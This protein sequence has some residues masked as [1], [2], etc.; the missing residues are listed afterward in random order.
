MTRSRMLLTLTAL[1]PWSPGRG[2]GRRS[3]RRGGPP[4]RGEAPLGAGQGAPGR[5]GH[6]LEARGEALDRGA[7]RP[8][9]G[10]AGRRGGEGGHPRLVPHPRAPTS[11]SGST[12]S[13]SWTGCTCSRA[14]TR[15][16]TTPPSPRTCRSTARPRPTRKN[17]DYLTVRES[18]AGPGGRHADPLR[19]PRRQDRGRLQQRAADRQLR[20]LRHPR[21][22][23]HA[24]GHQQLRLPRA[25]RLRPVRRAAGRPDLVHL[26]GRG[27][28]PGDGRLQ[29]PARR[30]LH[31]PAADPLR[32]RHPQPGHLHRLAGELRHLR[33]RRRRHRQRLADARLRGPLGPRLRLRGAVAARH[34]PGDAPQE[35]RHR[36]GR[37]LLRHRRHQAGL[38]RGRQRP[39]QGPR[40]RGLRHLGRHLR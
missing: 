8:G 28:L 6:V 31:P 40:R 27:Q 12:A 23:L 9:R 19:R 38:R 35:D 30:D 36:L 1:Q 3:P 14:T 32:L 33:P 29:R 34:D 25:P 16:T 26:H 21:Q 17:R 37:Q 20:R 11:R 7:A 2:R 24:A 18:R 4:R 5:P 15:T 39:H 10:E 22:R 13:P